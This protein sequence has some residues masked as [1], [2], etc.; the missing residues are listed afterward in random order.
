MWVAP[1]RSRW[2]TTNTIMY[3]GCTYRALWP[4]HR[5][6]YGKPPWSTKAF[7]PTVRAMERDDVI[8]SGISTGRFRDKGPR[9]WTKQALNTLE[10]PMESYMVEVFANLP[11]GSCN[12]FL[13]GFQH[14]CYYGEAW[15]SG[16]ASTVLHAP[17][18]VY[19]QN[20]Q[21][22]V[23]ARRNRESATNQE[24]S[25]R[26]PWREEAR[27]WV[28]WAQN[29]NTAIERHPAMVH[30]THTDGCL[31]CQNDT[32]TNLQT[33]WRRKGT[34]AP[35]TGSTSARSATCTTW[36]Q[37]GNWK[38]W[39]RWYAIQVC[40]YTFSASQHSIFQS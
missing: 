15:R 25:H 5:C 18:L 20:G 17:C 29:V 2:Q 3:S 6:C 7:V 30:K 14:V 10:E 39:N 38:L 26:S 21:R 16:T 36:W 1:D 24:S 12:Y 32:A 23:F 40:V 22:R 4:I 31:P 9:E 8:R 28:S 33:R 37:W 35:I 34:G 27:C 19:G 11:L 13:V